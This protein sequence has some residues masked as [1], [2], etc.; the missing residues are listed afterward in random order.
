MKEDTEE[1]ITI[2]Q[3][4]RIIKKMIKIIELNENTIHMVQS[5]Y[6]EIRT[7]SFGEPRPYWHNILISA[8]MHKKHLEDLLKTLVKK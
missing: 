7:H 6:D 2:K 3:G 8:G 5:I 1:Y 4:E